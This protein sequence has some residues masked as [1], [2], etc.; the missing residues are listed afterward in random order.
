[1]ANPTN[2]VSDYIPVDVSS[3]GITMET[4][5]PSGNDFVPVEASGGKTDYQ[6]WQEQGIADQQAI[7]AGGVQTEPTPGLGEA[8]KSGTLSKAEPLP[9]FGKGYPGADF[10]NSTVTIGAGNVVELMT[11]PF[12]LKADGM[13]YKKQLS[14][15]HPVADVVAGTAPFIATAP[16]FPEGLIGLSANFAAVSGM[17]E[18]GR[19][20]V[21]ESLMKPTASKAIDVARETSK[22]ALMGPVWHY[23]G[24]LNF[25]GRPFA[26]ALVRA[27]VRGAGTASLDKVYGADLSSAFKDGGIM[28]ALSLV[29]ETPALARTALGRGIVAHS[30]TLEQEHPIDVH[31]EP[32]QVK[33]Q[34]LNKLNVMAEKVPDADKNEIMAASVKVGNR[35]FNGS[36]HEEALN[37]AGLSKDDLVE[38][39]DY[40]AG[41]FTSKKGLI[42]REQ[43]KEEFGITDSHE[44]QGLN[45]QKFLTPPP[46]P[47]V[48]NPETIKGIGEEGKIDINIV[49]GVSEAAHLLETAHREY[50][51]VLTPPKAGQ[52]AKFTAE[53][54]RA[55]TGQMVRSHD[56]FESAMRNA[57]KVFEKADKKSIIDSYTKAERGEKQENPELQGIYDTLQKVML[58]RAKKVQDLG[59][60]KLDDLIENYLPQIWTKPNQA[61][62]LFARAFGK[63][64]LEGGKSFLKKR[65]IE[66]FS[67]GIEA[68]LEPVSW[69]PVDLAMIKLREMDRYIMAHKTLNALKEQGI[70]KLTRGPKDRPEGFVKIDD[71]IGTV[72][73]KN[74]EGELVLR[75]N[76]YAQKDAARIINNYLSP[77]LSGKFLYD[78]Y[79]GAGNTMNQFQLGL[80]AFH[81]GFTSMDATI[82]KVALGLNKLASKDVAGA[83]KEFATAPLAPVTNY[84]QGKNLLAAWRGES[85][86]PLTNKIADLMASAG[87]RAKMDKFYATGMRDQMAKAIKEGKILTASMKV[88]VWLVEQMSRPI[89]EHIVPAQKAG[90]FHDLMRFELEAHPEATHE[91]MVQKAQKIWDSVDNRMG[92]LVYDNLFWNKTVKDLSMA[93]VRSLGWNLGT[94]REVGGGVKD[95]PISLKGIAKGEGMSYRTAYVMA[96]PM[97]T[98]LY[99]AI[100]Q[101]LATGEGPQEA[102]DYFF[103]KSGGIDK[104]GEPARVSL[105]TYM[106]DIYHYAT[107]PG[108]T[109]M[110]KLSPVNSMV[111][112]MLM[113]R[114]F[115]GTKIYNEDDPLVR[116]MIDEL[117]FAAS[118]FTPFAITNVGKSTRTDLPSKV[119]PFIGI[120]PAP[121]DVSMTGAERAAT[122]LSK[123]K[124]P[125]GSRTKEQAQ[126]SQEKNKLR[127]KYIADKDIAPLSEAVRE[128]VI[129][130]KEKK[131]IIKQSK[132]TVLERETKN[133]SYEEVQSIYNKA[134]ESERK[135]LDTIL[136]KKRE[137]KKTRGTWTKSEE[138]MYKKHFQ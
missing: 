68:G 119:Q 47:K 18:V 78:L 77:G 92:Q 116:K 65:I 69:N 82:S 85:N 60:G 20:R 4:A 32:E 66:D 120:T 126:H 115:Y 97:V 137:G 83:V 62:K 131:D 113:N 46:E 36:S 48:V 17:S 106:K 99:G 117:G 90:V 124:I 121:Y 79:R 130:I 29:F 25:V 3:N 14:M 111:A 127:N 55:N 112:D 19:Q 43:A 22:G 136:K 28:T 89:M 15:E 57:S 110:N 84:M 41:F 91:Q 10:L 133:L 12:G 13:D 33:S 61:Q 87:G 34:I 80:S 64:P 30:N 134:N 23:S 107:S 7:D 54:L 101:Y 132:L 26:S 108:R 95:V 125:V 31:A 128:G 114:D 102:R 94:I 72:Y 52:E 35:V 6:K 122:D 135:Q 1:M 129:T 67:K 59:T 39:K 103:P 37:R 105:P 21:D 81:L 24:A 86:D 38:G 70:V 73:S 75:G 96:L 74:E 58:D 104:N 2:T 76:W 16:L 51:E 27:G 63:R 123:G 45:Q 138:A 109:L 118:Q 11:K 49:P 9:V 50:T 42:S 56:R 88:P 98:A 100:Y 5:H 53:Q 93:S 8:I 71:Q 44:V 40:E